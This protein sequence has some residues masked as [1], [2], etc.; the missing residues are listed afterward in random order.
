MKKIFL[1]S[2]M[3]LLVSLVASAKSFYYYGVGFE[4]ER[5]WK[6]SAS[7][8]G[9][10]GV[11]DDYRFYINLSKISQPTSNM[12]SFVAVELEKKLETILEQSYGNKKMK[13]KSKSEILDGDV[14]GIP[15]KYVDLT[16]SGGMCKRYYSF[17]WSGYLINIEISGKGGNFHKEFKTILNS[18]TFTPEMR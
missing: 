9:I 1:V 14:N 8:N 6:I 7:P 11:N 10:I 17:E 15:A 2:V 3:T 13:L 5:S 12:G 4:Y 16:F 18:F